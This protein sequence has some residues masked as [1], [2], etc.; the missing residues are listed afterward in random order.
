[1]TKTQID[2]AVA[3]LESIPIGD[4]EAVHVRADEIL[5]ACVPE[6]V[7]RTYKKIQEDITFWYA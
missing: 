2:K 6:E 5:L 4:N 7:R 3:D 1:M